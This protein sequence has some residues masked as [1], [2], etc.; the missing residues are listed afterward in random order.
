MTKE[1]KEIMKFW[2]FT[3]ILQTKDFNPEKDIKGKNTNCFFINENE[4]LHKI[5][6]INKNASDYDFSCYEIKNQ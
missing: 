1:A 3:E 5:K 6:E 4:D 2:K